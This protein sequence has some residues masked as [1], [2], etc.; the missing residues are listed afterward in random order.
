MAL[1]NTIN[2][3][4]EIFRS[5]TNQRFLGATLDQLTT[6]AFNLPVNGYV[7]RTFSPTYKAND[8]YVPEINKIRKSYQLEPS[9]VIKDNNQNILFTSGY[10]DL[11]QRIN[12][13]G[14]LV[15]DHTRLFT[16]ETYNYD[17]RFE[18]DK[19]V[20]YNK[21]YWLP[22]GPPS[23]TVTA[24]STPYS[25][26]YVVT[27]NIANGGYTFS[28]LSGHPDPQLTL[29]RGGSYTF[30]INQPGY[31]FWIQTQP[32]TSGLS[33]NQP[34]RS[35]REVFG[36]INNG[37]D[38]G[39][40]TINVPAADEQNFYT[41]MPTAATVDTAVSFNYNQIQG[42][43]LSAFLTAYPT[44]LDGVNTQ[45]QGKTLIFVN[46][47]QDD[48][49]W[50]VGT[51]TVPTT[52]RQNVWTVSLTPTGTGDFT[53][54]LNPAVTPAPLQK[55]YVRAGNTYASIEFWVDNNYLFN[56]VPEITAPSLYLFYQ[57][58]SDSEFFG[59][60]KLVDNAATPINIETDI[61]GSISY[62][63]PNGVIFTNGLKVQFDTLVNPATY[64]NNQ[65][66]VEGVGTS[67]QLVAV[68]DMV[69]PEPFN[70]V[71]Q[72]A[73]D[74]ITINRASQD[75]NAWSRSNRWFHIDALNA[76][77][78]YNGLTEAD[79]GPNLPGRRPII[80]FEPDLQLFNYGK[81]A[82][83]IID[84]IDFT[85]G[86]DAFNDIQG[87]I[88]YTLGNTPLT[89]GLR[90]I[91]AT[92]FDGNVRN[93]IWEV[94]I[95][96]IGGAN[97]IRLVE[98][99]DNPVEPGENVLTTNTVNAAGVGVDAALTYRFDGTDWFGSQEKTQINQPPLFDLVDDNGYSFSDSTIY[100][101]STFAGTKN[102]GYVVN[103]SSTIIDPFL[104]FALKYQTFNNIGDIVFQSYFET[105]TFTH[106]T[107]GTTTTVDCKIGYLVKNS[108]LTN[109]VKINTWV[110]TAE[111]SQQ[112]QVITKF[113]DG[114]LIPDNG[115]DK[116]FIQIDVLPTLSISVPHFKLYLNNV[117]QIPV[118]DYQITK[119]GI[120]DVVTLT[121]EP[122]LGDKIDAVIF[123][124]EVSE[125]GYYEIP[126]NLDYNALNANFTTI[127]LGQFR[128]HYNT[129]LENTAVSAVAV[130]PAQDRYIKKQVGTLVQHSSPVIYSMAFLTDPEVSYVDAVSLARKEYAR[131]KN[132]FLTLAKNLPNLDYA[133]VRASVDT[134]LQTIKEPKNSGFPWYYSDMVP[135]GGSYNTITYTVL[136][137][138]QT[139]YEISSI[140][141]DTELSDRA[142]L[143]YLNG[144]LLA[145]DVDY[146]FSQIAPSIIISKTLAQNDV[147]E[148][149][150]YSSTDGN[151][152]PETPTKLGL[153][154]KFRPAK[155]LDPTYQIPVQVIRGHDGSLTPAFGDYRDEFLIEL[156]TRIYNNI[157][158][159]YANNALDLYNVLPGRFRKT[160]Y[161]LSEFT[162]LL[163]QN[164]L[165]WAGANG[166]DFT[167]N[168]FYDANNPWTWN[169]SGF[170]DTV[171]GSLLQGSW[172][173]V[174]DYWFDTPT[175]NLDP[176]K[177]LGLGVQP[178][179]WEDRYGAAP[180]T[181]GNT[182]L[183]EDLQNGYVWNNG[184]PYTDVR[185]AR[186]GLTKFI[187]VDDAGNLLSPINLQIIRAGGPT[188]GD[189]FAVGQQGPAETAWRRSSDY[190][191]ALQQALALARPAQYFATQLDTSRL[192]VRNITGQFSDSNNQ[193]IH[194]DIIKINGDT[195]SVP[196]TTLRAS[197]Y[198]NWITDNI[199]NT[200]ID[201]VA[202]L[203]LYFKNLSIQLGYKVGGFT[204]KKLITVLAEQ[205][206][207][208]SSNATIVVP[209][210]NY[211]VYL[212]QPRSV[213]SIT[214][215]A[216]VVEKTVSGYSVSGYDNSNPFFTV[217]PSIPNANFSTAEVNSLS[218]K[219]YN[220]TTGVEYLVPYGTTFSTA[221]QLSDFLI[222]YERYLESQGFV[223]RR[224]DTDLSINRDWKLSVREF[225]FWVQQNWA[226]G[227]IL[228]LNPVVDQLVVNTENT[229][230]DTITNLPNGSRLLDQNFRPI[231]A[232]DFEIVRFDTPVSTNTTR[233]QSI[234]N[235]TIT[236]AHLILV[237]FEH[238]MIF[239]NVSDFGDIIYVPEQGTRQYRLK[240]AGV[241]AGLW[242][243][244]LSAPGYV[245]SDPN[246][247]EWQPGK[248]YK[249]GDLVVYNNLYYFAPLKISASAKFNNID[250]TRIPESEINTGLLPSLGLNAQQFRNIYDID[251][252][253]DNKDVQLF[254]AG[255]IGFRERPYFGNLGIS[256]TNQTKF[257]QG[258]I[259]QKG[260]INS[261][262]ALTKANFDN[263]SGQVELYE[264][265]AFRV[266]TYGDTNNNQFREFVLSQ[267]DFPSS[268]VAFTIANTYSNG[269]TYANLTLA[270]LYLS[271][272][273]LSTN[274]SLYDNRTI[275]NYQTDL[276]TPGY[277]NIQD[278]DYQVFDITEISDF[279][280]PGTGNKVWV[281]KDTNRAWN[282]YRINSA[283]IL[284]TQL[285]YALDNTA[286]LTF[287]NP[288]SFT[289]SDYFILKEFDDNY[290]GLYR[291]ENIINDLT[292][293]ITVRDPS[294]LI[295]VGSRLTG[296]GIVYTMTS[297]VIGSISNIGQ[298][299]GGW[300]DYDR[301][302]VD[303]ATDNGWGVYT[304]KKPWLANAISKV[305]ANPV[306]TTANSQF[307]SV[308]KIS[309]DETF[310]YT[311][312]ISGTVFGNVINNRSTRANIVISNTAPGFGSQFESQGNL[313]IVGAPN[314]SNV[315]IYRHND[316]LTST[317]VTTQWVN[318]PIQW[319]A[320]LNVPTGTYISDTGGSIYITTGNTYIA[321]GTFNSI[322]SNTVV[323]TP[324]QIATIT[325]NANVAIGSL[326]T[327]SNITYITRGNVGGFQTFTNL[328]ASGNLSVFNIGSGTQQ[329][330]TI[331]GP[332][333]AARF[334]TSISMSQDR[335]WLYVGQPGI[336]RVAAYF[337]S[338]ANVHNPQYSFVQNISV[339]GIAGSEFGG[340]VK[341]NQFGNILIVSAPR[342]TNQFSENGNV[343]VFTRT[344]NTWTLS[345]TISS[346]TKNAGAFFGA[347][348]D[349]DA[350]AGNLFIGAPGASI[351]NFP[352]GQIERYVRT[353]STYAYRESLNDPSVSFN[354]KVLAQFGFNV[355]VTN[356]AKSLA[357]GALS[358][359]GQSDTIFDNNTTVIDTSSTRFIDD[360]FQSGAV[361]LFELITDQTI[362]NDLG[363]YSFIQELSAPIKRYDRYGD[364]VSITNT[365]IAVG[366]PGN[367]VLYSNGQIQTESVGASY[368]Y[369]NDSANTAWNLTRQQTPAVDIDSVTRTLIYN[370][371]NN[372]ILAALDFIDPAKGKVLNAVGRDIDYQRVTDPAIY[373][374]GTNAT[375]ANYYWGPKQVGK[376]WWDLDAVRYINYEQSELSYRITHWGETFPGSSIDVYEWVESIYPPSQYVANVGDGTPIAADDSAY[377]TYGYVDIQGNVKLKYYYWVKNK[378]SVSKGK[379]NSVY[380]IT[381]AIQNPS[382]QGIPYAAVIRN[383]AIALYGVNQYLTGTNSVLH[384]GSRSSAAGL[385]HNEYELVQEGNPLSN[386]PAF[387]RNKLIDSLSGIDGV[388]NTV[389]DPTLKPSQ[390]YGIGIRPRQSMFVNRTLAISNYITLVNTYLLVYPII[391]T[392]IVTTLNSS[393]EIPNSKL[394]EY[395]ETVNT[396]DTLGYLSTTGLAS[397]YKV[398]VETDSTQ[399]GKWTIYTWNTPTVGIWNLT[400][401]QS[402]KTNLYWNR[403]DWSDASYDPS[404]TPD[405]T[406]ANNIELGK[407]TPAAGQF[408]KVLNNGNNKFAVY[409]IENDL[410]RTLVN[411]QD[412]TLQITSGAIPDLE[413]RQIAL[414]M[415]N[416]I[417]I[418]DLAD[419]YN[420][421]FFAMIKYALSEQ[422]N[423]DWVFKTSFLSAK[424]SLR[425]LQQF[426]AY[427]AD[428]Q[429]Y[430][431]DY[432]NEVK[433]YRT[434]LREFIV[435]YI[436]TDE[437]YAD[438]TDFDLPPYWDANV[439]YYRSPNGLQS[440]DA[441][442]LTT[443]QYSQWNDNY[444]YK[445]VDVI[446]EDSGTG[447]FIPP[448]V[449]ISGGGG[450]GVVAYATINS[451]GGVASVTIVNPGA[452]FINTPTVSFAGT[453]SG[454]RGYA[455]LRNLYD[456][457]N[458]GHNLIRTIK[459]AVKFDRISYEPGNSFVV[460]DT[461]SAANIGQTI[462]ENTVIISSGSLFQL[463]I[464]EWEANTYQPIGSLFYYNGNTYTVTGTSITFGNL[465][466]SDVAMTTLGANAYTITGNITAN[467]ANFPVY[468]VVPTTAAVFNNAIDRIAALSGTTDF[469]LD[470]LGI[471]YPGVQVTGNSYTSGVF[472][473]FISS[474]YSDSLGIAPEEIDIEGGKYVDRWSSHAPEE[475]VPGRM[476]DSLNFIV[477]QGFDNISWRIFDTMNQEHSFY[478]IAAANTTILASNLS[479]T[480]TEIIVVDASRLPA[481]SPELAQPGVVF[482]NG[483]KI[484][485]YRNYALETKTA[486]AANLQLS[487]GTLITD[488]GNTYITTGNVY[489]TDGI[490]ANVASNVQ[491]VSVN[492]LTQLR[493]A[494]DGTA[495][496]DIHL[497]GTSVID[498]SLQQQ[499]PYT[500]TTTTTTASNV[501]LQVV[502]TNSISYGLALTTPTT[503]NIGDQVTVVVSVP[504]W[505]PNTIGVS[506]LTFN[507]GNTYTVTGNTYAAFFEDI[508]ITAP[509]WTANTFS[510]FG[511]VTWVA[512][513]TAVSSGYV[514]N[515]GN[516]FAVSGNVF[517][518]SFTA[519]TV[520]ANV[521]LAWVGTSTRRVR[522]GANTFAVTGNIN[523]PFFAN[524]STQQISWTPNTTFALNSYIFANSNTYV[525]TGNVNAPFFANINVPSWQ[526][527]TANPWGATEWTSNTSYP[528]GSYVTF[529][530]NTF[531]TRGNTYGTTFAG[532]SSNT[533]L[534]T[535]FFKAN[536]TTLGSTYTVIGNIYAPF[537]ANVS[538]QQ[539]TWRANTSLSPVQD[540]TP[541]TVFANL[542]Y[543][544]N[545]G[546]SFLVTGNV[547]GPTFATPSVAAN[548]TLAF[549]GN[550]PLYTFHSG[551]TYTILGNVYAANFANLIT[552]APTWT[553][554]T[555]ITSEFV[556][557]NG[558]TYRV[559]G[560]AYSISFP[561]VLATG[562]VTFAYS[563]NAAVEFA[564]TGNSAVRF[565]YNG[566]ANVVLH[567]TGN[568]A[569]NF[570][571]TGNTAVT[572]AFAGQTYVTTTFRTLESI[573]SANTLAVIITSGG[574]T[575]LPEKFDSASGFDVQ[576]FDNS[577]QAIFVQGVDA[578][579][580]LTEASRLGSTDQDGFID[581]DP[582]VTLTQGNI[583][584][585]LGLGRPT[586]GTG[587]INSTTTQARFL[588]ETPGFVSDGTANTF[589][590]GYGGPIIEWSANLVTGAKYVSYVGSV[591]R[592]LGNVYA[593]TFANI[594]ANANPVWTPSTTYNYG[595]V[596]YSG[597]TYIVQ[598]NAF[599]TSFNTVL[600]AGNVALAYSGNVGVVQVL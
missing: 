229:V 367:D 23:V 251:Q 83:N 275:S 500:S 178:Q 277:V 548:V 463:T 424:Q 109:P 47:N 344:A 67:I 307:G 593:P 14:G 390:A 53:I 192:R 71:I 338:N 443:G 320:G 407:L 447:Y 599:G 50:T 237:Q 225:L 402:Y 578:N 364:S 475:L 123:S 157:K 488:S 4:P 453:G 48:T 527:N 249:L 420:I 105:D 322:I 244:A 462:S 478:R 295:R 2:F 213:A 206:S 133:D 211:S 103:N 413:L 562:N 451:A 521:T 337:T 415:Q 560:N 431:L 551:N 183:W 332:N 88:T 534:A 243:G 429:D 128:T 333:L 34:T 392:K 386:I 400:R 359:S 230:V 26:N 430:Y 336:G 520:A 250:W 265:W 11:L 316:A 348:L 326:L 510:N 532:I 224:F 596:Y 52:S 155:F 450:S 466:I 505:F 502:D 7:G 539:P 153:Y 141:N 305:T 317:V 159:N 549:A 38:V 497:T 328:L 490:F 375:T 294:Y 3:L 132:K 342:A 208:G 173:A 557:F 399:D 147:I 524:I 285:V 379:S 114:R 91:F 112:Y 537:F 329:L 396:I 592:T 165:Q 417:F 18:Y 387:I 131:F 403:V 411:I 144:S 268:P 202:K 93:K 461:I 1:V 542:T 324:T 579:T 43:L 199:K 161:S 427:I 460:W 212:G 423:L 181:S 350:T 125:L 135:Q 177:M 346:Q 469:T 514:V 422:K 66:Y 343:Y 446:I 72:T 134:I 425:K 559:S 528:I 252:P 368:V 300:R 102:F 358:G 164:F 261:I 30:Q 540:W 242:S 314:S 495:P 182:V 544:H 279:D 485:Y 471:D 17:G 97:F 205:T 40:I 503:A 262:N 597:N 45:L 118:T 541:D 129:L 176:W 276:P 412:G 438:M 210:D 433:P 74:Y 409:R 115:V 29:A 595:L 444:R 330:Q 287:D 228:V 184:D 291:I 136:N 556:Y 563:G 20:N 591:Y 180:Y 441:A 85:T 217:L 194:P 108:E 272:N 163:S 24:G 33:T 154:P 536:A 352:Q 439:Q 331:T 347:S 25:A 292:V 168:T 531:V 487:I 158:T 501:S 414:A 506:T 393:E 64:A 260:T 550:A 517:G 65:Y 203:N 421:L 255:L 296:S 480:D 169:Y 498:S 98:A 404:S 298:A 193:K 581:I 366:A 162:Q 408:I 187:P 16:C 10:I 445:V 143:V 491:Q 600:S 361:F 530:G 31:R 92:D 363:S 58:S 526:A 577:A 160:D 219:I 27:R 573:T 496:S 254:S 222:S 186:P 482:I 253:P 373:N 283:E 289:A 90:I 401:V 569:V 308:V 246:I 419:K 282:V 226:I 101:N 236:L 584:Y 142:V 598:S 554:N 12:T 19:F 257:Y 150:E 149:R 207:P 9:V 235:S 553:S 371:S 546:N 5:S 512:N 148:I 406:V 582:G 166:V 304:F 455:V 558:D 37:I 395:D 434:V 204:D 567:H 580:F 380:S 240:L 44:G 464:P 156:E 436:G 247:P 151:Y 426:P 138:R 504:F 248:D 82:K 370:R 51:N 73:A 288:H 216:V 86:R 245:Y 459:T 107:D 493:R 507:T 388:G 561:T 334:G 349:M 509:L 61:I 55:V 372:N 189:N 269:G 574:L 311:G 238:T 470:Q 267:R 489:D 394:G 572:V 339:N 448:A 35:T 525:V 281:A 566:G 381:S 472:D 54:Q 382:A 353:G 538:T 312:S 221:Q 513:S 454:A 286:Q 175:P 303:Q 335:Q 533:A 87:Q 241:K 315:A 545:S 94:A 57:D 318:T 529:G 179:W 8:N 589:D 170:T 325:A 340:Y 120:Y 309:T 218:V 263:L 457:N 418:D 36:V 76:A 70:S 196:G 410:T 126:R 594:V 483:E 80:E 140:F 494:V 398:L 310:A 41:G 106:S 231:K 397:G 215:S 535:V 522:N 301:L 465:I 519:P 146:V 137:T 201:P 442:L 195:E 127:A 385:V 568:T 46:G 575:N 586:N 452:G 171:D 508:S 258:Y 374:A 588:K 99:A 351:D 130:I 306:T 377:S 84:I 499:V 467:T 145:K 432:I 124:A 111:P 56:R 68:S 299:A 89:P 95:E 576:A 200:G 104:G 360:V 63:S 365:A 389:P 239:D 75:R 198:L 405:I 77:A 290:N 197:G 341:T 570:A 543:V 376:I 297:S 555:V 113:Y 188:S 484:T 474:A 384:I 355:S 139:G 271:S 167:S 172:R 440:Y 81:N 79:L 42:Q 214:Y 435:D 547:F 256:V 473:T 518:A 449:L 319:F 476:Y 552:Q 266:G 583:W 69:V 60:I 362:S 121:N 234:N 174:Y 456:G 264:E 284:A 323:A 152:V 511:A 21:Y 274:N 492:T 486:W 191:Y 458:V 477:N 327:N 313:L 15:N 391:E 515:N 587:L 571:Y 78:K 428:N 479:V 468:N 39:T 280:N 590:L 223:F 278:I 354:S 227:T 516:T 369:T 345:Q 220:D 564:Y 565:A 110:T 259:K 302:W 273:L 293:T 481:P 378:T 209:E 523:A 100:P 49:A 383:D 116:A 13:Y 96:N 233:I 59:Q 28:N 22:D 585:D 437:Y 6:D 122:A 232:T 62:T 32:G 117:L 357:V 416:D 119:F 270:N 356:N 321:A 190:P 185:F